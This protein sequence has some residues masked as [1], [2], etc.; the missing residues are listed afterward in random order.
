[1]TKS[2]IAIAGLTL[3]IVGLLLMPAR[4]ADLGKPAAPLKIAEWVKGKAVDLADAKGRKVVVVEFWATWCPPCRTSIPHLTELQKK[5]KDKDVVFI[6]VT[7]E[8]ADVVKPFVKKMGDQMDYIVAIDQ[9]G[10]TAKGYMEAYGQNGIPTAF[11]VDKAGN[12]VWVGHPM[13]DLERTVEAVL[14]GTYDIK[15]AQRRAEAMELVQKFFTEAQQDEADDAALEK[16]AA[17]IEKLDQE[18]GGLFPGQP[19]TA[20]MLLGQARAGKLLQR[21]QEAVLGGEDETK[22]AAIEAEIRPQLPEDVDFDQIK[23]QMLAGRLTN[24]YLR[25]VTGE[26]AAAATKL[27]PRILKELKAQPQALNNIAWTIATDENVKHRDLKFAL[28]VA[29]L[30][31]DATNEKEPDIIDTYARVLFETGKVAEAVRYEEMALKLAD[32]N[33]DLKAAL[34]KS[35][36]EFRAKL[37]AKP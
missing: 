5:F 37:N 28:E 18:V 26:D 15:T 13:A 31:L 7:D 16:L 19:L 32:D 11:V 21:Y 4:T 35:L 29:K 27:Q 25:A 20:K 22:L 3:G 2:R 8:K 6:G 9:D 17:Q 10:Q 1:M 14:A 24:E 23:A 30:A 12:V 36:D 34:Q 33:P